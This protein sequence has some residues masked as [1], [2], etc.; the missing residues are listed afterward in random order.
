MA[1]RPKRR[2]MLQRIETVGGDE[3]L[4]EEVAKGRTLRSI[5]EEVGITQPKLCG[6]LR[7][8]KRR[9]LYARAREAAAGA[10]VEQSLEI[11]DAADP[12][13]VQV[14]KLRADTRRWIAGK[15]DRATWGDDRGPTVA[16]QIN[17]LHLDALRQSSVIDGDESSE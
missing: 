12:A 3:W 9:E 14:A 4:L 2:S 16:I 13:T 1:G 5:A 10:L 8:E 7:E 6:Y 17:G 15:Y 11:V